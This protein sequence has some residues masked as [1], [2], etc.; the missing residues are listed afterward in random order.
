LKFLERRQNRIV[1]AFYLNRNPTLKINAHSRQRL[2]KFCGTR[3][4]HLADEKMSIRPIRG[5]SSWAVLKSM[6]ASD[7][8]W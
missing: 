8:G 3:A 5:S 4:L 6:I 7:Q 1:R 2:R